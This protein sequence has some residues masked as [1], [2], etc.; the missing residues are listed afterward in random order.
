MS[1]SD[2]IDF[3]KTANEYF[4]GLIREKSSAIK[5]ELTEYSYTYILELLNK[6]VFSYQS[7]EDG[8][9]MISE[10]IFLAL[11]EQNSEIKKR[12]LKRIG[13]ALLFKTGFF[14]NHLKRKL[15][16]LK[17]HFDMGSFA[18]SNLYAC[19][20]SP[21]YLELSDRFTEFADLLFAVSEELNFQN[22]GSDNL[23][24]LFDKF[25]NVDSKVAQQ[26]LL[27]RG[28]VLAEPKTKKVS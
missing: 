6:N 7:E 16:G 22:T 24:L 5:L 10:S 12:E 2:A 28:V 21:V 3:D 15:V 8:S 18:Y 19:S 9:K 23:L 20:Y 17:Y 1:Q 11:Q 26:K 13:D 27:E 25:S 14:S 4:D